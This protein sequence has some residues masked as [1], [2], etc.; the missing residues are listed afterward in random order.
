MSSVD[1]K[2]KQV[3]RR[4]DELIKREL[5]N[6]IDDSELSSLSAWVVDCYESFE[7]IYGDHLEKIRTASSD[8]HDL[9]HDCVVDIYWQLDHIRNHIN[10]SEKA[11]SR[12]MKKLARENS[13]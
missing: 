9:I 11:F 1:E 6:S 4:W 8:N 13:E 3:A 2:V 5:G 7:E 12:L 10:A